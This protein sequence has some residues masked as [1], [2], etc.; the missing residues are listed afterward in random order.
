MW[1]R[2]QRPRLRIASRVN[3]RQPVTASVDPGANGGQ[4]SL[5]KYGAER[6]LIWLSPPK[7]VLVM[8][9]YAYGIAV[10]PLQP[11]R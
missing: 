10:S 3:N 9:I 2:Q 1:A 7:T 5:P 6:T 8:C 4:A 11:S